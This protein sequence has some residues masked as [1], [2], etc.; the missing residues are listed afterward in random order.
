MQ[1]WLPPAEGLFHA[2]PA[3]CLT[4]REKKHRIMLKLEQWFGFRFNQKHYRL[5]R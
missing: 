5:V 4:F 2:A 1:G 3:H